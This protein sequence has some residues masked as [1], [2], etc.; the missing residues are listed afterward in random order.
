MMNWPPSEFQ[1][2]T[3]VFT[4]EELNILIRFLLIFAMQQALMSVYQGKRPLESLL[5]SGMSCFKT[6]FSP[7]RPCAVQIPYKTVF[8]LTN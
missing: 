6:R 8:N 1:M 3:L 7:C 2:L 4:V 5:T